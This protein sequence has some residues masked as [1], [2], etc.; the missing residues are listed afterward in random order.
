[1]RRKGLKRKN[2]IRGEKRREKWGKKGS[3]RELTRWE[4]TREERKEEDK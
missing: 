4:E 1:M 3:R 2:N